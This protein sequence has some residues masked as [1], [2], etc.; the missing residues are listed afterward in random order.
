MVIEAIYCNR[1]FLDGLIF[2][3]YFIIENRDPFRNNLDWTE[4]LPFI[5]FDLFHRRKFINVRK[6][7]T[8]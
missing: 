7:L 1:C 8:N 2:M 6:P 5:K 4:T 3:K